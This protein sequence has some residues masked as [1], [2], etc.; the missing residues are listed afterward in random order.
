[1][2]TSEHRECYF[3]AP[4]AG[5]VAG[6]GCKGGP[7]AGAPSKNGFPVAELAAL[8]ADGDTVSEP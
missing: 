5:A 1:M 7:A 8:R 4:L 6:A 2:Y 3:N